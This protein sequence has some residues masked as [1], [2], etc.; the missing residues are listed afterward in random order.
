MSQGQQPVRE[1][2]E[3]YASLLNNSNAVRAVTS[4]VEG[5]SDQRA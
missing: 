3:R 5:T 1:G 4:A 2:E